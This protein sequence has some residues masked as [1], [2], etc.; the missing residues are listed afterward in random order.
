MAKKKTIDLRSVDPTPVPAGDVNIIYNGT[1]I[2][3]FSEDT[4]ATLKTGGTRVL[5]DINVNYTKP[6]GESDFPSFNMVNTTG[7]TFSE[8]QIRNFTTLKREGLLEPKWVAEG[9][10]NGATNYV[11]YY[12]PRSNIYTIQGVILS[13]TDKYNVK[14]NDIPIPYTLGGYNLYGKVE[15]YNTNVN[16][17]IS[18]KE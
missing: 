14:I 11:P 3:G 18:N 9:P 7:D 12:N 5:H 16:I 6:S 4:E 8:E 13:D 10:F 17:V 1:R 2:G 15:G